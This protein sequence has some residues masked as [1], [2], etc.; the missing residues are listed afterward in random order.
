VSAVKANLNTNRRQMTK[1]FRKKEAGGYINT[2]NTCLCPINLYIPD[3]YN[4]LK[5]V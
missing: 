1:S 3:L 4:L 5:S 2:L